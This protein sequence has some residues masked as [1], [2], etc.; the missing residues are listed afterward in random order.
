MYAGFEQPT[1]SVS[2]RD[3]FLEIDL[4][5]DQ[6]VELALQLLRDNASMA[7]ALRLRVERDGADWLNKW[8]KYEGLE[9]K[10]V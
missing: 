5:P 10:K 1:L 3:E 2:S 6:A 7:I 9:V 4:D 8:L